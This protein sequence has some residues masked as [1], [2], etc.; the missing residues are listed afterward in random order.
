MGPVQ[1]AEAISIQASCRLHVLIA[2]SAPRAVVFRRGPSGQVM[3]STWNLET[4]EIVLGQWFRGRVYDE[5]ADLSPSGTYLVYHAAK[6]KGPLDTWTAISKPPFWT[7]LVVYPT[8]KYGGGVFLDEKRVGINMGFGS[9][10][11]TDDSPHPNH[12]EAFWLYGYTGPKPMIRDGWVVIQ[13]GKWLEQPAKARIEYVIDPPTIYR[14]SNPRRGAFTLERRVIGAYE[15]NGP[16][17]VVE[18]AVITGSNEGR[19]RT[20]LRREERELGREEFG[21]LDWADWGPNGDLLFAREGELFRAKLDA[22]EDHLA[23]PKLVMD[24]RPL[25]FTRVPPTADALKIELTGLR[26]RGGDR[27]GRQHKRQ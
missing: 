13:R 19:G 15:T 11:P 25:K 10:T 26:R 7:A 14:R 22:E 16:K 18:F 3:L 23:V 17:Q 6:Y 2:R 24:F 8:V 12:F 1:S 4:D 27:R 9:L 21:R 5:H 20:K